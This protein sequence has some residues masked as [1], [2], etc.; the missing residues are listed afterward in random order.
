W[1]RLTAVY[2]GV[3]LGYGR[4]LAQ[5][6]GG[7]AANLVVPGKLGEMVKAVW[8]DFG[9][10]PGRG[11]VLAFFLVALEKLLDLGATVLLLTG[12][13]LVVLPAPLYQPRGVVGLV[14]A[15]ALALWA[16]AGLL[17]WRSEWF[18]ALFN[19]FVVHSDEAK[20]LAAWREALGRR[21]EAAELVGWSL[22][23]WMVQILQFWC[24]FRVFGADA[25]LREVG[26][27]APLGLLAGTI[28]LTVGGVGLRDAVLL[29]Y[30]GPAL[31]MARVLSVGGL[32]LARIVLPSAA[33]LPCFIAL[34]R[35]RKRS[36]HDRIQPQPPTA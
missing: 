6:L 27:G 13:L 36:S 10:R 17:L 8:L 9:D 31:G 24:M 29:W 25:P 5:T 4:A 19:R 33:G 3:D 11:K 35:G 32:S 12:A 21:R 2:G 7:Y 18:V 20:V 22:A 23:L 14:L 26:V 15:G 28:P 16:A 34:M 30:F 1:K